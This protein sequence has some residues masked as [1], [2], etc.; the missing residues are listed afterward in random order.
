MLKKPNE[1]AHYAGSANAQVESTYSG[2]LAFVNSV[3]LLHR[4]FIALIMTAF[5]SAP[6]SLGNVEHTQTQTHC[7]I[8]ITVKIIITLATAMPK[9]MLIKLLKLITAFE[10]CCLEAGCAFKIISFFTVFVKCFVVAFI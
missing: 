4:S 9:L 1:A 3:H 2:S 8:K 5:D 6:I 10:E 7:H